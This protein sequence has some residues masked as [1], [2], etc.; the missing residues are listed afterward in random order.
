[1]SPTP[2]KSEHPHSE[3]VVVLLRAFGLLAFTTTDGRVGISRDSM[4]ALFGEPDRYEG[5]YDKVP[6]LARLECIA[7]N[8]DW[9][10]VEADQ[11]NG[12]LAPTFHTVF[13]VER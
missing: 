11:E 13:T 7:D 6:K 8:V 3:A 12:Y 10:W 1:M 9:D 4:F 2:S 5:H